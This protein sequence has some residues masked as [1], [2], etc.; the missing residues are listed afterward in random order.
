MQLQRIKI[1]EKQK[2]SNRSQMQ[3]TNFKR[4]EMKFIQIQTVQE[5]NLIIK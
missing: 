2:K 1:V 4:I 3:Y 5:E